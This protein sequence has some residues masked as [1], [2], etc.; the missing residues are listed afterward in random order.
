M[1]W[2]TSVFKYGFLFI[3]LLEIL[4][5]MGEGGFVIL[6]SLPEYGPTTRWQDF[7]AVTKDQEITGYGGRVLSSLLQTVLTKLAFIMLFWIPVHFNFFSSN[8]NLKN[9]KGREKLVLC[10]CNTWTVPH[11]FCLILLLCYCI[12]DMK[13]YR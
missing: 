7:H 4:H 10:S 2:K 1:C 8:E 12:F 13:I 11:I 6:S 5:K 3:H 9:E